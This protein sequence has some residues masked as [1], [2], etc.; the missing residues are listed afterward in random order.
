MWIQRAAA[1]VFVT[2]FVVGMTA[3]SSGPSVLT[4]D[5]GGAEA[6]VG[7]SASSGGRG[8]SGASS[9]GGSGSGSS[10]GEGSSSGASADASSGSGGGENCQ[11]GQG[12]FCMCFAA[13]NMYPANS[14]PCSPSDLH[15]PGGCCAA[16][17]WPSTGSCICQS[18][19]CYVNQGGGRDC[20]Y[21]DL[22]G[23]GLEVPTTSATGAACCVWGDSNVGQICSCYDDLNAGSC[24]G[25]QSVPS[26][27][28][29]VL[30]TCSGIVTNGDTEVATCR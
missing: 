6:G 22:G 12:D 4:D 3:C 15:D 30:S 16:A 21:Q 5:A 28:I 2:S 26:C 18:F 8:S 29:G 9:S 14:T 11:V 13:S 23:N 10:S 7:S 27:T 17:G 24:Q 1:A 25:R 20:F 19:L